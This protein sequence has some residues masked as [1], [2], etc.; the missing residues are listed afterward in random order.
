MDFAAFEG[1]VA[2]ALACAAAVVGV[3]SWVRTLAGGRSLDAADERLRRADLL[4]TAVPVV[5]L[6]A[7]LVG[8]VAR[9]PNV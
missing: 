3:A 9:L 4:W 8:V 7:L 5:L 2:L 6:L 1:S